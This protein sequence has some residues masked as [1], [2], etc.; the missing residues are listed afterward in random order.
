MRTYDPLY[1]YN[2]QAHPKCINMHGKIHQNKELNY[3]TVLGQGPQVP[4]FWHTF[5][6][7]KALLGPGH[8][9]RMRNENLIFLFL[10]QNICCGYSKELSQ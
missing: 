1:I 5:A 3:Y 10:N 4:A 6:S 7:Y 2:G 9:L 8:L